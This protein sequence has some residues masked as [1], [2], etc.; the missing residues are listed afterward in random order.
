MKNNYSDNFFEV[1]SKFGFLPKNH[2][3]IKLPERYLGLQKLLDK[4]PVNLEDGSKGYLAIPNKIKVEVEE[5]INYFDIV[6]NETDIMVI[7]A[8]YRGYCFLASAYT[9]ELSYQKFVKTKKYGKARQLLPIQIAQP[10]VEVAEKLNVYPW[11]DYHYAY[12]LG[13]Y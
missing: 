11:L 1:G 8:L 13:N 9:L 7:Q 4:M 5:L 10:F 6:K 2:P 3:L 12:S